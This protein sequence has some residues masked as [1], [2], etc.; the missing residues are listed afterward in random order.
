MRENQEHEHV[1][2]T[3]WAGDTDPGLSRRVVGLLARIL[4]RPA[5][6]V[7][8]HL[9]AGPLVMKKVLAND[10]LSKLTRAIERDGLQYKVSPLESR[11]AELPPLPRPEEDRTIRPELTARVG[12]SLEEWQKGDVVEGLYEVLGSAAG[13]M[14]RVY[15]VFHRIWNM[16][17]AVKTPQRQAVKSEASV[18]RFLREAELWV[19]L[20]LHPNIAT[21]YYAR[22]LDGLPRLFIEFVDGGDLKQWIKKGR[23]KDINVCLDVMLQFC[24]GMIHAEEQGMIHRDIKPANCLMNQEGILKIT[25]FGLVKRLDDMRHERKEGPASP[26][27]VPELEQIPDSGDTATVNEKGILGSPWFMAPERIRGTS[28]EDIRSDVYSFGVMFYQAALGRMP[29]SFPNGFSIRQLIRNHVKTPPDDPLSI[30]PDLPTEVADVIL[31]CLAKKPGDRFSSFVDVCRAIEECARQVNPASRP[32]SKPAIVGLKTDTLNNQAVSLLDLG[33][34]GEAIKLLEDAYSAGTEHLQAIYNLYTLKWDKGEASDQEVVDLMDSLKIEVRESADFHHLM[35]LIAVQRGDMKKGVH[36]LRIACRLSSQYRDRWSRHDGDPAKYFKSLDVKPTQEEGTLPGHV[37]AVCSIRLSSDSRKAYSVGEDRSIRMWD[38]PNNRCARIVRTFNFVPMAGA[39]SADGKLTATG[40]GAAFKT[41]DLWD[42]AQQRL[43]RKYGGI[44]AAGL[45]FSPESDA[46]AAFTEEGMLRIWDT[47]SD[48]TLWAVP[49][50]GMHIRCL[51]FLWDNAS[52]ILGSDDGKL[53]WR[54]LSSTRSELTVQAHESAVTSLCVSSDGSLVASGA[55]DGSLALWDTRSGESV[56][57]LLGHRRQ[58]VSVHFMPDTRFLISG[59]SDGQVK[60]WDQTIPRCCRTLSLANEPLSQIAVSRDGRLLLLA[61]GRG[62]IRIWSTDTSAFRHN[63]IEPAI[64]R[65]RTF[66]ELSTLDDTFRKA[67]TDFKQ[68]W[69]QGMTRASLEAFDRIRD[70]PGYS[71]SREAILIRNLLQK[72]TRRTDLD[73]FAFVRSLRRHKASVVSLDTNEDSLLLLSGGKDGLAVVWD[74]VTGEALRVIDAEKP[75]V[76]TRFL[77]RGLGF[78]TLDKE[79]TL[80][81]WTSDGSLLGVLEGLQSPMECEP[82]GRSLIAWSQKQRPIRVQIDSF[83]T[84]TCGMEIQGGRP[85]C[86]SGDLKTLFTINETG[87]VLRWSRLTGRNMGVFRD[88]G[89]KPTS[90][91]ILE[92]G[93]R[94]LAGM[95]SGDLMIYLVSSG[96]NISMLRGHADAIKTTDSSPDSRLGLTGSDDCTV[97]VWDLSGEQCLAVLEGHVAPIRSVR[98]FPNCS[99]LASGSVDGAIRL[100]GLQW[101]LREREAS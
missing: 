67:L 53:A 89:V 45:C 96:I 84:E 100:W 1:T 65:P 98:W 44:A 31:T 42:N 87:R 26:G 97:R 99:M 69:R 64:C 22:V 70:V 56:G 39:H 59:S 77:P 41:V 33:Y 30:R 13:G 95:E 5:E 58:I 85:L 8:K 11:P 17:L 78:V 72:S 94:A 81:R 3:V 32:R 93:D 92:A 27:L 74:V 88:P 90:L 9:R 76:M 51:V 49:Q 50:T 83:Q 37:K 4:R 57:R 79:G 46:L 101:A 35:G 75:L 61:G 2:L 62:S 34:E 7:A 43:L 55:A 28:R 82:D 15:F 14:G 6:D 86:F 20:G 21:C 38:V 91:T 54:H 25:D 24:H 12:Q 60:I 10:D 73:S 66:Q 18:R 68:S 19:E 47:T 63:H 52:V 36:M 23:V 80:K 71:W 29:F 48:Q 16:M 40:Y